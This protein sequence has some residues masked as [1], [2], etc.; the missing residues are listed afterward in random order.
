MC[1]DKFNGEEI[2]SFQVFIT[3]G[4]IT[5]K[6]YLIKCIYEDGTQILFK[7]DAQSR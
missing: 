5:G 7:T 1:L 6:S 3:V 4:A 2:K